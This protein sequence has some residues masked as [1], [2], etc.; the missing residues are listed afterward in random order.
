MEGSA[1]FSSPSPTAGFQ[2]CTSSVPELN[3][4]HWEGSG[5]GDEVFNSVTMPASY[6]RFPVF[7]KKLLFLRQEEDPSAVFLRGSH[8]IPTPPRQE[9]PQ[10]G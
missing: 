7:C 8:P 6:L 10:R 5:F 3:C 2:S 9:M 4:F 1:N